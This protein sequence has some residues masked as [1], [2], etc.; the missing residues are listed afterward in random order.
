MLKRNGEGRGDVSQA[1]CTSAPLPVPLPA[2]AR[3]R[4]GVGNVGIAFPPKS[5][6]RVVAVKRGQAVACGVSWAHRVVRLEKDLQRPCGSCNGQEHL[7]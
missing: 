6:S 7:D 4:A 5:G 3:T 1:A 2:V